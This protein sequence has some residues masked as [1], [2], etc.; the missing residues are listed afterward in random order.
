MTIGF[1]K[2]A[3]AFLPERSLKYL[4]HQHL[5]GPDP[6]RPLKTIHA[7][8]LTKPEGLCP[9]MYALA[10]V[11]KTKL[12]DDWLTTSEQATYE[13]G[14]KLQDSVVNWFADMGRAFCHWKCLA[15]GSVHD[16]QLRPLKC[17]QCGCKHF[18]PKE[19]RFESAISGASCGVDVMLALGA[20]KL[21]PVEIKTIDKDEFKALKAPLA[22][23]RWRTNLYLRIIA[24]SKE[25]WS[26]RVDTERAKVLYVS[27]GGYGCED[28][29]LKQWGLN[30]RYSP[31]KEFEV[32]RKDAETDD[33][34]LRAWV[35]SEFR[36]GTIGMPCGI[37][38]TALSKRAQQCFMKGPCFSGA[39]PP[40]HQWQKDG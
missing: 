22:E 13:L 9:R 15:C 16:F 19:P 4:L 7:S 14:R 38:T 31:F 40:E 2:K 1:L 17:Q 29:K 39:Y 3:K 6:P 12:K 18:A 36:K 35:V 26:D 32:E 27:K 25:P 28:D 33:L 11:T 20:K 37:C 8:E 24:E 34:M 21:T 10:D 23:H 30:E 5:N